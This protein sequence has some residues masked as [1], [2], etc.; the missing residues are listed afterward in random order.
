VK[1]A[2]IAALN[3]LIALS[4]E[5]VQSH[6]HAGSVMAACGNDGHCAT[7]NTTAPSRNYRESKSKIKKPTAALRHPARALDANGNATAPLL[8]LPSQNT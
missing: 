2:A 3:I 5:A 7:L 6:R 8:S 4:G 1:V